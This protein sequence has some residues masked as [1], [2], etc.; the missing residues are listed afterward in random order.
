MPAI[1]A[2]LTPGLLGVLV[3]LLL[4]VLV[5]VRRAAPLAHHLRG[6]PADQPTGLVRT[7]DDAPPPAWPAADAALGGAARAASLGG[8]VAE[9]RRVVRV[10]G[11]WDT[12]AEAWLELAAAF[13]ETAV[14]L[15]AGGKG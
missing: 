5:L 6:R 10:S 8:A 12:S 2:P 1:A 13:A 9:L 3:V 7:T 14:E 15:N 4:V 11:G